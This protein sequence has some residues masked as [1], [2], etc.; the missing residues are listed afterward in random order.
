M[1][2]SPTTLFPPGETIKEYFYNIEALEGR[3][4]SPNIHPSL[5]TLVK[6]GR[7]PLLKRGRGHIFFKQSK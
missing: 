7:T 6:R 5:T 2:L 3:S 4:E 1:Y